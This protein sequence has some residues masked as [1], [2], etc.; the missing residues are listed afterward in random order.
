[1]ICLQKTGWIN[2][3]MRAMLVSILCHHFYQ[4]WREGAHFL[5]TLFLDYEPGIHYPQV[6][7]QAGTT[8]INTIRIYNPVKQSKDHD[9][10][11]IFIK[12]WLP[13]LR[14]VPEVF[15]HEPHKMSLLDQNFYGVIIG[16]DYPYPVI[17]ITESAKL[18]REK[19]WRHRKHELVKT[20]NIRILAKHVKKH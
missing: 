15:I 11:G 8:G 12:K 2:F 6:Q 18:A 4:D 20:E 16:K 5:A 9:P 14:A 17:N 3:R 10:H 19:I 1:M 7:M 13:P